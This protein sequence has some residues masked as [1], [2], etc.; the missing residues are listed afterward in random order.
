MRHQK[1]VAPFDFAQPRPPAS[2]T[3]GLM[4]IRNWKVK[5]EKAGAMSNRKFLGFAVF[6]NSGIIH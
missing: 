2:W 5:D 3:D 6:L 4:E 1:E